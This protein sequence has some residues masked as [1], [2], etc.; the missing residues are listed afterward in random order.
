M[1]ILICPGRPKKFKYEHLQELLDVEALHALQKNQ[2]MITSNKREKT[3][4]IRY[5]QIFKK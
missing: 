3:H 4:S 5:I 2:Q 1:V